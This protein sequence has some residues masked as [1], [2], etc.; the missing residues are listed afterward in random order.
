MNRTC[1]SGRVF[2]HA[3]PL[4]GNSRLPASFAPLT[5]EDAS[6]GPIR[7]RALIRIKLP[8]ADRAHRRAAGN[9]LEQAPQPAHPAPAAAA[10][11]GVGTEY[12]MMRA[13]TPVYC[14]QNP[15]LL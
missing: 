8:R 6:L 7:F 1:L 11:V 12:L 13:S 2:R 4:P 5:R 3:V 10:R 14:F 15:P 9:R